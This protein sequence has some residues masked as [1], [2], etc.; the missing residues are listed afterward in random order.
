MNIPGLKS[1]KEELVPYFHNK[2]ILRDLILQL[3]K[4]FLSAGIKLKL[5]LTKKYS[6][7]EITSLIAETLE[8]YPTQTVFNLLYRVDVSEGQL[9]QAMPTPGI[10]FILFSEVIVKRELQKVV[11]RRLYSQTNS[12]RSED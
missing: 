4:D 6:F 8:Q 5:L 10:D 2:S 3:N 7:Q 1:N 11:L 12:E 9:M